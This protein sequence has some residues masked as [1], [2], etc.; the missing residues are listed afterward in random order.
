M[1]KCPNVSGGVQMSMELIGISNIFQNDK[2][3][4]FSGIH[5][6]CAKVPIPAD[7]VCNTLL[8]PPAE[9]SVPPCGF[10][11]YPSNQY[12]RHTE[13]QTHACTSLTKAISIKC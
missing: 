1:S 3:V 8:V 5:V 6:K 4:V 7:Q 9:K 12:F 11:Q 10:V 13:A 2:L